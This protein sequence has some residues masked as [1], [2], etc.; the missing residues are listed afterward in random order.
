[1]SLIDDIERAH[2]TSGLVITPRHLRQV[3]EAAQARAM[4]FAANDKLPPDETPVLAIVKG[5]P[6]IAELRW[7]YPGHEDTY[8]SYR[9][10][11]DPENDGQAW[12]ISDVSLW[13]FIPEQ[14]I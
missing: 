2:R 4:W 7:D 5:K 10:W 12:E 3:H 6:R 14:S 13:T 9:Y 8:Q 1:M 11:D